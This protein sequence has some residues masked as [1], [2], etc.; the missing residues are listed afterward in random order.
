MFTVPWRL[1]HSLLVPSPI[2]SSPQVV[3]RIS[4]TSVSFES[5][6]E[7][8]TKG[9]LELLGTL[10]W[11]GGGVW[12]T[13]RPF[14]ETLIRERGGPFIETLIRGRGWPF[15]ETLIREGRRLDRCGRGIHHQIRER[16]Y[17]GR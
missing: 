5:D 3:G 15:I 7:L 2:L 12:N 6:S 13:G 4:N 11:S 1:S 16:G 8:T 10:G 14:I 17:V 9:S